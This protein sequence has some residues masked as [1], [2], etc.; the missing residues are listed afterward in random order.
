MQEENTSVDERI[1]LA[2]LALGD[3]ASGNEFLF[4]LVVLCLK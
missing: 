3:G 1:G 4:P 2:P